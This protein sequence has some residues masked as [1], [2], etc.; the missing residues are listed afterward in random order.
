[1]SYFD[2]VTRASKCQRTNTG[3]EST[4]DKYYLVDKQAKKVLAGPEESLKDL[5]QEAATKKIPFKEHR[6]PVPRRVLTVLRAVFLEPAKFRSEYTDY[7]QIFAQT[8][9]VAR[10]KESSEHP[11]S[12]LIILK[13]KR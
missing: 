9:E 2:A 5:R 12:E 6:H 11:G 4:G 1:M 8:E 13:V 10:F 3:K 7:Q